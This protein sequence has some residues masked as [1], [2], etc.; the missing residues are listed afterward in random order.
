MTG[1]A[2][3]WHR[4]YRAEPR[5]EKERK[6]E[7]ITDRDGW[8]YPQP[9]MNKKKK[10]KTM[11]LYSASS[12]RMHSSTDSSVWVAAGRGLC[13]GYSGLPGRR[14]AEGSCQWWTSDHNRRRHTLHPLIDSKPSNR[15]SCRLPHTGHTLERERER[16][17]RG[18]RVRMGGGELLLF[19]KH[20]PGLPWNNIPHLDRSGKNNTF[21]TV[22]HYAGKLLSIILVR[23]EEKN[24]IIGNSVS[25]LLRF[26][27]DANFWGITNYS[28]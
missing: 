14:L 9:W 28:I 17:T 23:R 3:K 13:Q 20:S 11:V 27:W 15:S 25:S 1:R 21:S 2:A 16:E 18:E 12:G 6:R 5:R 19:C 22:N 26:H 24:M 10:S 8:G 4:K 7:T